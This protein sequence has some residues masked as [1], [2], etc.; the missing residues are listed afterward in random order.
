MEVNWPERVWVN[1]PVR[2]FVQM[3]EVAWFKRTRPLKPGGTVLEIGCG[4]GTGARMVWTT[5]APKRIEAIDIDPEMI[6]LALRKYPPSDRNPIRFSVADAQEL[7]HENASF[8]AVFNFGIIHHLEDWRRGI[9]EIAR[10]LVKGGAFYFEE[11]YPPLYA[12]RLFRRLLA[13]PTKDRFH[14]PE[15]RAALANVGLRLIPS[16]RESRFGILGIAEKE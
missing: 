7:P 3:R 16:Y 1:S 13:H 10:V 2:K 8:Q 6:K 15:F 12:N 5:F 9:G 14:G 4:C 11:I